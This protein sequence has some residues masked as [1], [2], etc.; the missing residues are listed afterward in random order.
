MPDYVKKYKFKNP[1]K[2]ITYL[3]DEPLKLSNQF[4]FYHNKSMF[5]KEL[6][7]LQYLFKNYLK[8]PLIAAGIRDTYLKEE[9]TAKYFIILF[10][11]ADVVRE[12][13]PIIE[14]RSEIDISSG[15]FLMESTTKYLILLAVE[16]E[17]L[18]SGID[19]LEE[20]FN[21]TFEDYFSRKNFDEFIKI[22]PFRMSGCTNPS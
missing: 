14:I 16:M 2:E 22:G 8:T 7:R 6:N 18:I 4:S 15:C 5:R 20:I 12:T 3:D 10:T 9:Y 13:N 11:T 21:Q 19:K 17:G 1:P